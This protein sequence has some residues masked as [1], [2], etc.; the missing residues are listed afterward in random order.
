MSDNH[1]TADGRD[2]RIE[3][4]A[5]ELTCA[6]Y[7]V[8][9]RRGLKESW[10]KVELGLWRALAVTIKKWVRKKPPAAASDEFEAWRQGLLLDLTETAF[11][12]ALKHRSQGSLA[13]LEL[14]LY[15]AVRLATRRYS[16]VRQSE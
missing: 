1:H 7:P 15:R 2:T 11:S 10:L 3:N 6:V 4:F 12:I 14:C 13:Q 9:L 16:R 8:V 5:A